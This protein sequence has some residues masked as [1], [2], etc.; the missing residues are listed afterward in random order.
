MYTTSEWVDLLDPAEDELRTAW[1]SDVH[2]QAIETLLQPH[3][4][5]DEPR[6]KFESHGGYAFAVLLVPVVVKDEDRVYYREVDM[7]ITHEHVLTVRKTPPAP[8]ASATLKA[9]TVSTSLVAP[10]PSSPPKPTTKKMAASKIRVSRNSAPRTTSLTPPTTKR[11]PNSAS[12]L[13]STSST[14]TAMA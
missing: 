9:P 3:T 5:A 14:G 7:L 2:P 1:P 8:L 13:P 4:H 11:T 6:P 10:T 12:P